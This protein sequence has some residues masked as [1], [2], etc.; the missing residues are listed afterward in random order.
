MVTN[1]PHR[2]W[3]RDSA[4]GEGLAGPD[5]AM[6]IYDRFVAR[7]TRVF[8]NRLDSITFRSNPFRR[9]DRR[10]VITASARTGSHL[11]MEGLLAHGAYAAEHFNLKRIGR[12]RAE[13]GVS[14]LQK[15]CDDLV[16]ERAVGGVFGVK[17]PPLAMIPFILA[18]E[19]PAHLSGWRFVHLTRDNEVRQAISWMIGGLTE[20]WQSFLPAQRVV[21]DDDYDAEEIAAWIEHKRAVNAEWEAIFRVFQIEPLRITYEQL[22]GDVKAVVARTAA[23]LGLQGPPITD[24]RFMSPP[25]EIQSTDLN[26]RWE[27]RFRQTSLPPG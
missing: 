5:A 21:T 3:R 16:G 11:L 6:A 8:A 1:S 12:E 4:I 15:Y 26:D 24:A 19:F 20:A 27:A 13:R 2:P 22:A 23:H 17:G 14:T 10:F 18:G 25:V 9:L 7:S